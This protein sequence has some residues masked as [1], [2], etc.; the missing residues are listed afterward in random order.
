MHSERAGDAENLY[1]RVKWAPNLA[2]FAAAFCDLF[3]HAR[4][5]SSRRY[6]LVSLGPV[7]APHSRTPLYLIFSVYHT[8]DAIIKGRFIGYDV[9]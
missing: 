4:Q 8:L 5:G 6:I 3:T 1:I 9:W 7:S 2:F